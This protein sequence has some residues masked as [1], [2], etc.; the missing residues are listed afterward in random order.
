MHRY[1]SMCVYTR[2]CVGMH[3]SMGGQ[4]LTSVALYSRI[5]RQGHS[6]SLESANSA[7]QLAQQAPV[8]L[9]FLPPVLGF[10]C[11]CWG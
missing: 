3:T 11:G 1:M 5:L 7:R 9:L 4:R 6:L 8:I 2:V 10:L